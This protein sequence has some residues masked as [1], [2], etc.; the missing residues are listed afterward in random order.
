MVMDGPRED[1]LS[2]KGRGPLLKKLVLAMVALFLVAVVALMVAYLLVIRPYRLATIHVDEG[3]ISAKAGTYRATLVHDERLRSY[4]VHVPPGAATGRALPLLVAL[5]GGGGTA[6]GAD[7]LMK[8]TPIADREGFLVAFPN[9]VGKNWNDGRRGR[10]NRASVDDVG[11]ITAMIDDIAARLPVDRKRVFAAG[12]SN[13]GFMSTRL[14]CEAA[15]RIAAVGTV[16]ATAGVGFE[17]TCKPGRP[18]PVIAFL[19]TA[20]PLVPFGGG[21]IRVLFIKWGRVLSADEFEAF[22]V[23]N[24]GCA[25]G[26]LRRD[27]PDINKSDGSHVVEETFSGCKANASV[28]FFRV[29]GGGHTW[30]GGE[31]YISPLLAGKSNRDLSASEQIWQF[32]AAHP[33][34]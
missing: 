31:Q 8:L 30:P 10:S 1:G 17:T 23:G 2:L 15:D 29:V 14:A 32:F 16:D 24:N 3:P 33:L 5:H 12:I 9:A 20:D 7:D 28:D 11:F 18:V 21:D 4:L 6:E 34:P 19:G 25:P 13:G 22:W 27:W 26:P